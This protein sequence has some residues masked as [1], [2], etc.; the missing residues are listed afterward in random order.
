LVGVGVWCAGMN[1]V[2]VKASVT[3]GRREYRSAD[4]RAGAG[5]TGQG[6][7][8]VRRAAVRVR[9]MRRGCAR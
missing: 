8:P 9:L 1:W 5:G 2:G 6:A 3:V 4:G 7:V